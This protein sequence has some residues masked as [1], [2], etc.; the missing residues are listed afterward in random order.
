MGV[1]LNVRIFRGGQ[2]QNQHQF[3][4][5]TSRTIK[6]GRLPSAQ[7]KLEDPKVSR[8]HAVIEF[9]GNDATL[10]DMGSAQ[11]TEVNGAKITSR[12]KLTHGDLV[13]IGDTQ[14]Y[15][16]F[17][18]FAGPQVVAPTVPSPVVPI[19]ASA[20]IG[21]TAAQH[22]AQRSSGQG[23]A[24]AQQI[25]TPRFSNNSP[26]EAGPISAPTDGGMR[27]DPGS[28]A[29]RPI[30]RITQE[31]LRSAA[32]ESKP[33]PALAPEEPMT[34]ESRILELRVYW[35]TILLDIDHRHKPKKITIGETKN[36]DVFISSEGLPTEEFPLIRTIDDEYVL[37]FTNAMDGELE[38]GGNIQPLAQAR[39]S[40]VAQ[41]DPDF[42]GSYRV[43]MPMDS[44]AIVH[45]GGITFA[46]RFVPPAQVVPNPF[47]KDL[48]LQYVN[49]LLMSIFF[50]LAMIVTFMVLPHDTESL[51]EDIFDSKGT[52][53]LLLEPPKMDESTKNKL[54]E[55][56]KKQQKDKEKIVEKETKK[57]KPVETK[58]VVKPPTKISEV[59]VAQVPQ[60]KTQQQKQQE[61]SEK[62]SKL[63]T[64]GGTG[65][66]AGSILGGGG[67]GS[68]SGSLSNV[69]GTTGAGNGTGLAGLG[70]RGGAMTGGGIGT[71]RGIAGIGTAGR[72]GGGGLGYGANA[73]KGLGGPKDRGMVSLSTP[74]VM[75][76]LPREVIQKV[77]NDNKA[78]IR[79]CYEVELQRDQTLEGKVAVKWIIAATG[80]VEKVVVTETTVKSARV[81]QCLAEKIKGWRFP[82][83]AGGGIVEVNYPF[84][85]K[86]S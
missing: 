3:D 34:H 61:V 4:S 7:L 64:G 77:I 39:G 6:I 1:S 44:R 69:I 49:L 10:T 54:E 76:A 32:I 40:S 29:V 37:T 18:S 31:R 70:I 30:S 50:H 21:L 83:P 16:G 5:D 24:N 65:G 35:G 66:G 62:F 9:A 52:I 80:S 63:F 23:A 17:G 20:D 46:L 11:G 38:I 27:F 71:S 73:G 78:Q 12:L 60:Q 19:V 72:L 53:A 36:T 8:I 74:V 14:L 42:D 45:W 47:W 43:R 58:P 22:T 68:I 82:Q 75:G 28:S 13:T 67:G 15:F 48:D 79:Y 85:F 2:P 57:V 56:K 59:K 33:H 25:A 84:V 41:K 55:L 86:S 81:G 51:R 26:L